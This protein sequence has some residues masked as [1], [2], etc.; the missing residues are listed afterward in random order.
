MG[1]MIGKSDFSQMQISYFN[2][3]YTQNTNVTRQ[4]NNI[5]L[6][7]VWFKRSLV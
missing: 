6:Y 1:L 3:K 4:Q 2:K 7:T 5:S